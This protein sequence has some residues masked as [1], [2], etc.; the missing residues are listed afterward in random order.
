MHVSYVD[1]DEASFSE[2]YTAGSLFLHHAFTEG[3]LL[4]GDTSEWSRL[5]ARFR[6]AANFSEAISDY[7]AVLDYLVS[8][9]SYEHAYIAYLSNIFK[10]LKN[11]AIF[12]LAEAGNYEF[13]KIAALSKCFLLSPEDARLLVA[14][15][16]SFERNCCLDIETRRRLREFAL[17]WPTKNLAAVRRLCDGN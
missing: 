4:E 1:Y 13:D 5:N 16:N 11:I 14:S 17:T 7:T 3:L 9:P 6:V 10:A 12:R 8:Y 2:F 15:N